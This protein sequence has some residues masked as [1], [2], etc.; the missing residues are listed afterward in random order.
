M[1]D[2]ATTGTAAGS[3]TGTGLTSAPGSSVPSTT[4]N[5]GG[6]GAGAAATGTATSLAQTAQEYAG[7]VSDAA[8]QAKDYV[9][10]KV[11]VVTDKIKELSTKDFSDLTENAKEFARH[12]P[13]QAILISAGVGLLLGVLIRGR[14]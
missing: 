8:V 10:D 14:R 4:G 11:G 1:G 7:K 13:G 12:N 5:H 9:A 6:A 3:K 2:S